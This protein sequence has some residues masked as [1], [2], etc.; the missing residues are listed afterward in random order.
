MEEQEKTE[1]QKKD[2][3]IEIHKKMQ[4]FLKEIDKKKQEFLKIKK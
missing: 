4:I 2:E 1:E 3:I